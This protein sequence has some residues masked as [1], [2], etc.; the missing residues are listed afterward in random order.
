MPGIQDTFRVIDRMVADRV[1]GR[2]AV[3]GAVAALNYV[4][5]TLTHDVDILIS[6][7]EL[8]DPAKTGLVT[9]E[10]IFAYLRKAG[11]SQFAA[12]GIVIE[13]W[14]VQFLPVASRLD[15]EG[16]DQAVG[17]EVET[18]E[19]PLLV[20][21]LRPEHIVATALRVGRPKDR[22]RIAQFL[23][24]GVVDLGAL[25]AVLERHNLMRDWSA[26]CALTGIS[27]PLRG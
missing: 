23:E 5:P 15:A 12:E 8:Q 4:E 21:T 10:P 25:R 3:A 27:D 9:L 24:E 20:P 17:I 22:I 19:G 7:E 6:V 14:P 13:G 16:L 11:Y 18:T 26:F 2:Y 1:I